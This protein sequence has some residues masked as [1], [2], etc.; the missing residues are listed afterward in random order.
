MFFTFLIGPAGSGKSTL[1]SAFSDWLLDQGFDVALVNLDPGAEW[2]PYRPDVDARDYVTVQ[3]VM[4]RYNLGPNGAMI[5][6]S[7]LLAVKAIDLREEISGLKADYAIIDTPGQMELFAFRASGLHIAQTL[8]KGGGSAILFLADVVL[9]SK[10]TGLIST[11]FLAA[12]VQFRFLFPQIMV[13]TKSDLLKQEEL[14]YL[15]HLIENPEELALIAEESLK[16]VYREMAMRFCNMLSDLNLP[17]PVTHVSAVKNEGLDRLY[18]ILQRISA[19]G[20]D[21]VVH[22]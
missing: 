19:G 17:I 11:L 8:T 12:S 1:A 5:A 13:L 22:Y 21:F 18:S 2:L 10:P 16:G 9:A 6:A 3:E 20:E 15:V 7:D 14:T 4:E